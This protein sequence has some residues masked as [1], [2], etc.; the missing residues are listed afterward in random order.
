[1]ASLKFLLGLIPSTAKIEQT[2]KALVAEFEKLNAF[3]GSE[4]LSKYNELNDRV[5]S[6]GFTQKRKEI[7][8]VQY[9]KSE[10]YN[11]EKE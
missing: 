3:A 4:L 6:A 11:K 7:E 10:E 5:N 9:K 1:M 2:E 8:S